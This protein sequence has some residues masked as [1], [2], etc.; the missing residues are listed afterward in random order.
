MTHVTPGRV[1]LK[2]SLRL[3]L[4]WVLPTKALEGPPTATAGEVTLDVLKM[5]GIYWIEST[6]TKVPYG[7]C[8]D[9]LLSSHN[10]ER[11]GTVVITCI[12]TP[13]RIITN[14]NAIREMDG[15]LPQVAVKASIPFCDAVAVLPGHTQLNP[16]SINI[17]AG[18]PTFNPSVFSL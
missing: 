7:R 8:D 4:H 10:S 18:H 5:M 16:T 1:T 14:L 2:L 17:D 3:V 6:S 12:N 9:F 13:N 11:I 15:N